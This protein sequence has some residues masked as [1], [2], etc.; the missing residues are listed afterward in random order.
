M[1]DQDSRRT[2]LRRAAVAAALQAKAAA[3]A[4][5]EKAKANYLC[6][7]CGMQYKESAGPPKNCPVCD[8]ERQYVGWEGQRWTTLDA[9]R[10][11]FKNVIKEE[12]A[13]LHSII[14]EPKIGIGQR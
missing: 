1:T 12:A 3:L 4:A 11:K 2:F 13:G 10:G 6:V 9:M 14:N 7:T 5:D 8:D